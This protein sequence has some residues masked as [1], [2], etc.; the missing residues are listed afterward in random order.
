MTSKS[1]EQV[2]APPGEQEASGARFLVL[3]AVFLYLALWIR[4]AWVCDDAYIT[5]RTIDNFFHGAGLRWNPAE[6]V[7]TYTHPL[8]ALLLTI[9]YAWWRDPYYSLLLLSFLCSAG[10]VLLVAFRIAR[11]PAAA[12]L[13]V[14]MLCLSKA[15]V[16]YSSSGLENPATHLLL[17]LFLLG[18]LR[19]DPSPKSLF[20]LSLIACLGILNR[21]DTLLLY[22]PAL[23][24]V[25]WRVRRSKALVAIALAFVPFLLWECFSLLYYGFPFPNTAYAK[26]STGIS[27]GPLLFQGVCYWLYSFNFDPL[28]AVL[29]LT[30]LGAPFIMK[31]RRLWPVALGVAL[32]LTYVLKIGGDFM[33][34][35][36][37]AAP[38]LCCAVMFSQ[39]DWHFGRGAWHA[40][41]AGVWV[42]GLIAPTPIVLSNAR[43]MEGVK[44]EAKITK[45]GVADERAYYYYRT[46]LLKLKRGEA[47]P[48]VTPSRRSPKIAR[49]GIVVENN[50][51]F[52]GFY[53][54]RQR[55]H[56]LDDYALCDP[57]LSRLPVLGQWRI[58]HF[59]RHVPVGYEW[60]L[61]KDENVIQ[62]P[63]LKQFYD[64]VRLITRGPLLKMD[65]L[66]EIFRMNLGMNDHLIDAYVASLRHP[67]SAALPSNADGQ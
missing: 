54:A 7:Q 51:G 10:T 65:R 19:W 48:Y 58:G 47:W 29:I 1:K 52:L 21:M 44:P 56:V 40:A 2:V 15:F 50:T 45:S 31:E 41:L 39:W 60:S 26:L 5:F 55:L 36:F 63:H 64:K 20:W 43:Y 4:T 57:L 25:A 12:V 33:G 66:A 24:A 62:E 32:Y 61:A 53:G 34:G 37:F 13:A 42:L 23:V 18:Y 49:S 17:A 30:G 6:R 67:A 38:L 22:L 9:T 28:T 16:D 46:A 14:S 11:T 59:K 35:R 27:A 8:W 3:L